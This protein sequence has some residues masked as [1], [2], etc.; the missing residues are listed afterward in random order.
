MLNDRFKVLLIEDN[1]GDIRI[2]KEMF[3]ERSQSVNLYCVENLSI[4]LEH[5]A[6]EHYDVILLDLSLPDSVGLETIK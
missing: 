5:I 3:S 2:I 6:A 1:P 4:G